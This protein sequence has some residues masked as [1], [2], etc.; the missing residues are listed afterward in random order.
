MKDTGTDRGAEERTAA[1]VDGDEDVDGS[2]SDY[3]SANEDEDVATTSQV[4]GY[5]LSKAGA[6]K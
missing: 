4:N 6:T 5:A 2:C 3:R 1:T